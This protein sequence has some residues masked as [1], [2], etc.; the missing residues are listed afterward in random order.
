MSGATRQSLQQQRA[1]LPSAVLPCVP[2]AI[3]T[4]AARSSRCQ[5]E[6]LLAL[7]AAETALRCGCRCGKE[8]PSAG[9]LPH[10]GAASM[11]GMVST[12]GLQVWER[13]G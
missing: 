10:P 11:V 1:V 4:V 9:P 12:V 2:A 5:M 3:E 8:L 7:R 13:V 6:P